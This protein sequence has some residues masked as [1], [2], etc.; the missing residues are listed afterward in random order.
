MSTLTR[1]DPPIGDEL[2]SKILEA[3][4]LILPMSSYRDVQPGEVM[5]VEGRL[6]Y[7][8]F[9]E[10]TVFARD[11]LACFEVEEVALHPWLRAPRI[12]QA[13]DRGHRTDLASFDELLRRVIVPISVAL[14]LTV[15]NVSSTPQRFMCGIVYHSSVMDRRQELL[16][17][18]S[19][20]RRPLDHAREWWREDHQ[21]L[22]DL[23][24][25][26]ARRIEAVLARCTDGSP[27]R[28]LCVELGL[29]HTSTRIQHVPALDR[30]S[31]PSFG[32]DPYPNT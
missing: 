20:D 9:P 30:L 23:S 8:K 16:L 1:D 6:H 25:V 31:P 3:S 4:R 24:E 12:L 19:S 11:T 29:E 28:D 7:A 26:A 17:N 32:W 18:C 21:H 10:K 22:V 5:T 13:R 14:V 27:R 2:L 15:R